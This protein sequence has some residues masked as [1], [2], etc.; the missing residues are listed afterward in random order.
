MKK[1]DIKPAIITIVLIFICIV[2]YTNTENPP[3][4]AE[5]VKVAN[6]QTDNKTDENKK[7]VAAT[8]STQS[9][10]TPDPESAP[11]FSDT[12][13]QEHGTCTEES[14]PV[15]T[16]VTVSANDDDQFFACDTQDKSIYANTV[17]GMVNLQ[18]RLS[19]KMPNISPTTGEPEYEGKSKELLDSLRQ[20]A[21]VSTFDE[22]EPSCLDET[23]LKSKKFRVMNIKSNSDYVWISS[24]TLS[25]WIPRTVIKPAS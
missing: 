15:G 4:E 10:V 22:L 11:S 24:K 18:Y 5:T 7:E 17:A 21:G 13:A 3:K 14:C 2:A 8:P 16:F 12:Y 1:E 20:K 23:K 6:S 25:I 19:G 9:D